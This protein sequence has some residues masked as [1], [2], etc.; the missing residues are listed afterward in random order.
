MKGIALLISKIFSLRDEV[1]LLKAV[2]IIHFYYIISMTIRIIKLVLQQ[3]KMT[4]KMFARLPVENQK[5][6][7][8]KYSELI[9]PDLPFRQ[10][11]DFTVQ[12][13]D[14]DVGRCEK[15]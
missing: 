11:A 15:T 7:I 9:F 14:G 12:G 4:L 2:R 13:T 3:T 10:S 8:P 1:S 6:G 5:L